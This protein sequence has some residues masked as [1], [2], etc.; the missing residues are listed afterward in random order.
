[1]ADAAAAPRRR[2]RKCP[3]HDEHHGG[4]WKVAYADL[5]TAMMAFFLVMWLISQGTEVRE[6]VAAYF[7]DPV[8]F[9]ARGGAG[10]MPGSP[11]AG[12]PNATPDESHAEPDIQ[13]ELRAKADEILEAL[14][15]LPEFEDLQDQISVTVGPEGMR[16]RLNEAGESSFFALGKADLSGRGGEAIRA[17]GRVL[18]TLP[19]HIAVEGHTDSKPYA[20]EAGYTNWELSADRANSARRL[21]TESGV[22][23]ARIDA[24]RG[25]ADTRASYPEDPLDPRNRRIEILV[26]NPAL[27]EAGLAAGTVPAIPGAPGTADA[28]TARP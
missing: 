14:R 5:V 28:P 24:I 23:P 20:G 19:Y 21:L 25:Y 8:G 1:M 10:V 11:G 12:A 3:A 6:S 9:T 15:A 4:A 13:S 26:L 17:I 18:S 2:K 27:R 7:S 16:I 22:D